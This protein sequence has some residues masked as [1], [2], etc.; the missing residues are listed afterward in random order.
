MAEI[1]IQ[2]GWGAELT[3]QAQ[4]CLRLIREAASLL[5]TLR[6]DPTVTADR[7]IQSSLQRLTKGLTETEGRMQKISGFLEPTMRMYEATE[8]EL[9]ERARELGTGIF[10]PEI[11]SPGSAEQL[12]KLFLEGSSP[13]ADDMM[14]E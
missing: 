4:E 12:R 8:R 7:G 13:A 1:R 6:L 5:G 3:G 2:T 9:T 10:L 14:K 11:A